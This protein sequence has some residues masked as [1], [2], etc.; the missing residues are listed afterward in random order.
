MIE[1]QPAT[2]FDK[3]HKA[4]DPPMVRLLMDSEPESGSTNVPE[5][6][7]GILES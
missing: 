2:S 5:A 1:H 3:A 4:Y 6:S 7:N